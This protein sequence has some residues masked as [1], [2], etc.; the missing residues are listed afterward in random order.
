VD[1]AVEV[2]GYVKSMLDVAGDDAQGRAAAIHDNGYLL[3]EAPTGAGKTLMAGTIVEKLSGRD[4]V[5]WFWF[6]PFKGV[7]DQ[8]T[9][10]LR[11][12]FHGLRLRTLSK[13]RMAAG[14]RSG[15]VFVT[16]WQLVATRVKDQ[17]SVRQTGETNASVDDL[18]VFLRDQG[19]RIGVVVDEAHHGFH[20]ETQAA[21]F[22][23]TVLKSEY[24]ILVTATPDDAD[25]TDLKEQMQIG[26]IH[27]VTISRVDA[28][29]L[30]K[31]GIKCV[32][33]RADEGSEGLIDFEA[34]A[35]REGVTL[36]RLLK[37]ELQ[38]AGIA[39]VPL[40][41]VQVASTDKSVE[42][43]KEKLLGLGFTEAQ[44][45]VHTAKEPD[46]H[47]LALANDES[48]EV[49]VFKMA[50][51]LGFDAPRAW[52]LVS[53]RASRDPDFGVQLVG[54][55][56]RVHR[57]LQ[58]RKVGE[59]LR[60]G[61]VLLADSEAQTGIDT[62][63]QRMNQLQ[64]EYAKVS[65]T[66][67]VMRL[68][69]RD[70][71]Q[72]V[73]PDGQMSLLPMPPPGALWTAPR[74][75]EVAAVPTHSPMSGTL[76]DLQ[77]FAPEVGE[78]QS[79]VH[80]A[81]RL[82]SP[83]ARYQYPLRADVPRRFKTQD[84][85]DDFEVTEEDCAS[86]FVVSAEHLLDVL[87]KHDRVRVQKRT[88]EIFTRVIQ[89]ELAFAPPSLEQV[90]LM[91]QR[92]LLRSGV[93]HPKDLRIALM[94]RLRVKLAERGVEDA[95][96]PEKLSEYLDV[97]LATHPV[98]LQDAQRAALALSAVLQET[99]DLP[100][101]IDSDGPL[102]VSKLN[103]Y[104]V[105][106]VGMNSW[107]REFGSYLDSDDTGIVQWWH[108]NPVNKPWSIKLLL[109]DGRGFYPDFIVGIQVRKTENGGLLAD[110]KWAYETSRELPNLRCARCC[111]HREKTLVFPRK[112]A[113][114]CSGNFV[115]RCDQLS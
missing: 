8:T 13:D 112:K 75:P 109:A 7:V 25:L 81:L 91:A 31:D 37:A 62:A 102:P 114:F 95:D 55:I 39:L 2:F 22:F 113:I 54:R 32:A 44:I 18:I 4:Q 19:F 76:F 36:H 67:V 71:V 85:P 87:I 42:K 59:I 74:D 94:S 105:M 48:R 45:A 5:V 96:N 34:T 28:V 64:T 40:M 63:G 106:P 69:D 93:Y 20:S 78:S 77:D 3:I 103:I 60:F 89:M 38:A 88:L 17:R 68:G 9:A 33:W 79:A 66:T 21:K 101:R 1:S 73:G 24:T 49:L 46:A 56:L 53:M 30:I 100:D 6:A 11:E 90:R 97:L 10:F 84:L 82:P 26:R 12:Q 29:G 115:T 107:E 27:R 111:E 16:T 108:R 92:E 70:Q 43:V 15:D 57:R 41:L 104:E 52:T 23:R 72:V 98:L 83:P 58:G 110:T 47:L 99:D 35:L 65:R 51:A 61:Y 50:V 14:T 86:R 80:L